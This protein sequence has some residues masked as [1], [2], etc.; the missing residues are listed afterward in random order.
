MDNTICQYCN[1]KLR[2]IKEDSMY[3]SWNRLYHKSCWMK[4]RQDMCYEILMEDLLT[5]K[6]PEVQ[7][8]FSVVDRH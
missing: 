6:V 2:V 5:Q 3:S 4:K 7:V 1:K 8:A